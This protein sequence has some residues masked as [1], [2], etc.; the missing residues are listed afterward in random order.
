LSCGFQSHFSAGNVSSILRAAAS[1]S[2][3][4]AK[5]DPDGFFSCVIVPPVFGAMEAQ[6]QN[7][8][9]SHEGRASAAKANGNEEKKG[10]GVAVLQLVIVGLSA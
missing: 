2:N 10:Q 3:S 4:A 7:A 9:R 8:I 6:K 5:A 1:R